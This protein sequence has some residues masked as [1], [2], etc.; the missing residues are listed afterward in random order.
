MIGRIVNETLVYGIGNAL[1]RFCALLIFP[2]YAKLLTKAEFAQQDLVL[3]TAAMT[4]LIAGLGIENGYARLFFDDDAERA[5]LAT[6]WGV[7]S[8]L[9]TIP[10]I[11]CALVFRDSIALWLIKDQSASELLLWGFLAVIFQLLQRQSVLTIRLRRQAK[12]FVVV[13]ILG[14]LSQLLLAVWFVRYLNWGGVG[15][16]RSYAG[17][18]LITFLISVVA[19]GWIWR[20]RFSWAALREMLVIGLPLLPAAAAT[21]GLDS[22]NRFILQHV[23]GPDE[24][25]IYGVGVKTVALLGIVFFG[26]QMAWGPFAFSLMKDPKHASEVYAEVARWLWLIGGLAVF[27]LSLFSK[28]IILLLT[29]EE[30]LP[31]AELVPMLGMAALLW[32]LFYIVSV[33]FQYAKKTHHQMVAMFLGLLGL[34]LVGWLTIGNLGAIGAAAGTLVGYLIAIIYGSKAS[35]RY[36][37]VDY[38]WSRMILWAG[39]VFLLSYLL[40]GF[41][42]HSSSLALSSQNVV[43]LIVKVVSSLILM[44]GGFWLLI[45]APVRLRLFLILKERFGK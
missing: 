10:L 26:F 3:A 32:S 31:A 19:S 34:A 23:S 41:L 7:F 28:E 38:P 8:V 39:T 30:Y 13:S 5:N 33:G 1:S 29:K 17:A 24:T 12:R 45:E 44:S 25:A 16:L 15:V 6:T 4:A 21:W 9:T 22:L 42:P 2:I 27:T 37:A 40:S 43:P 14:A 35:S 20:G 36:L 11:I 18:S